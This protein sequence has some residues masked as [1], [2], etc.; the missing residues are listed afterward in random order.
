MLFNI[1]IE[2]QARLLILE[3]RKL[4]LLLVR[5]YLTKSRKLSTQKIFKFFFDI[6]LIRNE[7][8]F[9]ST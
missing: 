5:T 8:Y 4:N 6:E 3:I 1:S 9:F 7:L 2:R